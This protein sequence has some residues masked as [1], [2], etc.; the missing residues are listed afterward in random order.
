[1]RTDDQPLDVGLLCGIFWGIH[2]SSASLIPTHIVPSQCAAWRE[3]ETGPANGPQLTTV[4]RLKLKIP[5]PSSLWFTT[6]ALGFRILSGWR[7]ARLGN[8]TCLD[9]AEHA[10]RCPGP[11]TPPGVP[12]A[13]RG[14]TDL[15]FL[16]GKDH[17]MAGKWSAL[18]HSVA[19]K[20]FSWR[21][22]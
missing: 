12:D 14:R 9:V 6:W 1:M 15:L 19:V 17:D 3:G 2:L 22:S 7:G 13:H 10:T 18:S 8:P 20:T 5:A 11:G 16:T 4:L 21:H